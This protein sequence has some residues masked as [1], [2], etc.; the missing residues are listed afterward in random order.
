MPPLGFFSVGPWELL[1]IL[2]ALVVALGIPA[3]IIARIWLIIRRRR[4]DEAK[5]NRRRPPAPPPP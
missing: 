1:I 4:Q 5:K 3:M 2:L